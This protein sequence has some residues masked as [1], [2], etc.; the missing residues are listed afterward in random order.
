MYF[1]M[2]SLNPC[3]D[4]RY[5]K[6]ISTCVEQTP[7]M[8]SR[9]QNVFKLVL[10]NPFHESEDKKGNSTC[11]DQTHQMP[12]GTQNVTQQVWTIHMQYQ[13]GHKTYNNMCLLN[14]S[15]KPAMHE[16]A[17]KHV[18]SKPSPMPARNKMHINMC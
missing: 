5:T 12:A 13:R 17:S 8:P 3:N 15:F 1:N 2:C 4:S 14:P 9:T 7:P 16:N 18:L 11:Y 10:T 6:C